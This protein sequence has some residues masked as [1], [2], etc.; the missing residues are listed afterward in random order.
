MQVPDSLAKSALRI[1]M[2][3]FTTEKDIENTI[4]HLTKVIINLRKASPVWTE[5]QA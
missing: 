3:R 1:S 2:G 5:A 4:E